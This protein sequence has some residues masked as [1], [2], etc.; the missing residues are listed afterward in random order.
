MFLFISSCLIYL[1]FSLLVHL[2]FISSVFISC[3]LLHLVQ[4]LSSR[5]ISSLYDFFILCPH[6][7]HI[8][9]SSHHLP[10]SY[11]NLSPLVSFLVCSFLVTLFSFFS[12]LF[13]S[14]HCYVF[15]SS[16]LPVSQKISHVP[17]S[18]HYVP[19]FSVPVD[20]EKCKTAT[21]SRMSSA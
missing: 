11:I 12:I 15:L 14:S 18:F 4:L 3:L 10:Y 6:L 21:V 7:V 5:L 1:L 13:L 2:P 8:L 16:S 9:N 17:P 19:G 20:F